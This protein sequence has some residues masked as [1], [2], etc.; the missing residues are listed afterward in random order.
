L[1]L[2][3][4]FRLGE[5][6]VIS[7]VGGGGKTTLMFA[8]ARELVAGGYRVVTTTTTKILEAEPSL[9]QFPA[10][11]I[12]EDEAKLLELIMQQLEQKGQVTAARAR[13]PK[14]GKLQGVT[15]QMVDKLAQQEQISHI[16]V[17][18][19]G[20][21]HRSLKAPNST[22]PVIPKSTTLVIP[23]VGLDVLG[24]QLA[25]ENVFRPHLVSE[26]TGLLHAEAITVEAIATLVTHPKGIAKGTM[27]EARLIPFI[28]KL[29]TGELLTARE[30]A[31][32]ILQKGSPRM[33]RVVLGQASEDDP[34]LEVVLA[35][36]RDYRKEGHDGR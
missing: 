28:N 33:N 1:E 3:E 36:D 19:D 5:H 27:P 29:D 32:R 8:L 26:I 31:T 10:V 34:V 25:E 7:L 14:L 20:A 4:A 2:R 18:A 23:V 11:V 35:E 22:E 6:E 21:A 30:L 24:L 17:E 16:I 13:L 15:P 9:H 12:D